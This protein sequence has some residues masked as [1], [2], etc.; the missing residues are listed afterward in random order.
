MGISKLSLRGAAATRQSNLKY[1]GKWNKLFFIISFTLCLFSG[2]GYSYPLKDGPPVTYQV[3]SDVISNGGAINLSDSA[4]NYICSL[5]VSES[6]IKN[7][8]YKSKQLYAN[9]GFWYMAGYLDII[10]AS[11][12]TVHITSVTGSITITDN[13][14]GYYKICFSTSPDFLVSVT[15]STNW[16]FYESTQTAGVLTPNTTSYFKFVVK[17]RW[18][19]RSDWWDF[20]V[21]TKVTLCAAPQVVW[22]EVTGSTMA[23]IFY[24]SSPNNPLS[25]QYLVQ[26]SPAADFSGTVFSSNTVFSV[27]RSSFSVNYNTLYYCRVAAINWEGLRS[28][29]TLL[30]TSRYS[31]IQQPST[32]T[33]LVSGTNA[34]ISLGS[35]DGASG[36][37]FTNTGGN[38]KFIFWETITGKS[39]G[40]S[41]NNLWT[42]DQLLPGVQYKFYGKTRNQGISSTNNTPLETEPYQLN[43]ILP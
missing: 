26:L 2:T 14:T 23:V 40:W 16:V 22:G 1:M 17:D 30:N 27:G 32:G 18:G 21:S 43:I 34:S 35:D 36:Y 42:L 41:N 38:T 25:T 37:L 8:I 11:T 28:T 13:T 5:S 4:T 9:I 6:S 20:S 19:N 39:S 29:T 7:L 24:D 3:I 33:I 12:Y 31:Y 15:T 10:W